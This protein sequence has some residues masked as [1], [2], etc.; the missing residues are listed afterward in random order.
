MRLE[1]WLYSIPLRLRSLFRGQRRGPGTGRGAPVPCSAIDRR[2]HRPRCL[3]GRGAA[4]GPSRDERPRAAQGRVPRHAAGPARR[5]RAAGSALRRT[6]AAAKPRL[7][8][9]GDRHARAGHRRQRRGVHRGQRRAAAADAVSGT[10]SSLSSVARGDRA[11]HEPTRP[12]GPPVPGVSREQPAVFA[13]RAVHESIRRQPHRAGRSIHR[14][15]GPGHSRVLRRVA[16]WTG[17]R[18]H[19]RSGRRPAGARPRRSVERRPVAQRL[20]RRSGNHRTR[21]HARRHPPQHRR[22]DAAGVQ[23]P[24]RGGDLDADGHSDH[25]RQFIDV[26]GPR[27]AEAGRPRRAGAGGVRHDRPAN[28]QA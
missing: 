15:E 11:V 9:R 17:D 4:D 21:D 25:F 16:R 12:G 3:A 19:V 10:G 8:H 27:Q 5:G 23:L 18:A 2:A 22:R 13:S 26:L 1:R 6:H 28:R 20:R 7:H 24:R 14:P